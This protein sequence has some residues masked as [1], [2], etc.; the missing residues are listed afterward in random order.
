MSMSKEILQVA[1]A[2]SA[3]KGVAPDIIFEAIEMALAT[4]TK[5]RYD[6][7]ADI[8]VTIDRESGDY[9]TKR[10]C[11][12]VCAPVQLIAPGKSP[13]TQQEMRSLRK[14]T[15]FLKETADQGL[16]FV[17]LDIDTIRLV[18]LTDASFANAE[19]MKSQLGYLVL[20][21]D[22]NGN[23]N[24]V[25]YGS[26][27]CQRVARSV[28]AAELQALVLGFDYAFVIK[29]LVE[30]ILGRHVKVEVMVDS[31]T[32][33]NVVAKDGK[34]TERRLQIDVLA[35]RQSYDLGELDRLAWIPGSLNAADPLTKPVLSTSSPLYV[36]METNKFEVEPQG[37][38]VSCERKFP[39]CRF[40]STLVCS[41]DL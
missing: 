1:D 7:E 2:V 22:G 31:K 40:S 32:T 29:D 19:G 10:R 13:T 12:D 23:C 18:L 33:F 21:V 16:N 11:P 24:I 37:W 15:K 20:M 14:T 36:I 27:R 41:H 5:K 25:H 6:E 30:E 35:L 34:T 9:V 38:A 4:A 8:E 39:E 28:M 17:K 3:E 26:N